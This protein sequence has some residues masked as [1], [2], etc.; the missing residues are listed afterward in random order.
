MK[1]RVTP[2]ARHRHGLFSRAAIR[3]SLTPH[4]KDVDVRREGILGN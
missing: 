3:G 2:L 1:A 4:L